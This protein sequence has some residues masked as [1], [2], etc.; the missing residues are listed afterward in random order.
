M[1]PQD[2]YYTIFML[3]N[4]LFPRRCVSCNKLGSYICN[5]CRKQI[6]YI[7]FP[8][9]P[10]CRYPSLYGLIHPRCERVYSL[11]GLFVP[12]HYSGPV[13]K[14]IRLMKYR[15]VSDLLQ[16]LT[17]LLFNNLHP[18]LKSADYLV[19]VPL[20]PKKEKERG[21]N[22]SILI[23][24]Y[25][26]KIINLPVRPDVLSRIIY[27][28][29]QFGLRVQERKTN[30]KNIFTVFHTEIVCNKKIILVDDVA[31]TFSTLN[32]CTKTL[33]RNGAASV[34]AVVLAHGN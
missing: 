5:N 34:F 16:E 19:P 7:E 13:K 1:H 27:T 14:A 26:G 25:L 30:V 20:H 8:F 3:L 17:D 4:L 33:K 2:S 11:D 23:A 12:T 10:V 29:P 6:K 18:F 32:E 15:F 21:F 9:C 22:Q 24:E 31:T 28:K